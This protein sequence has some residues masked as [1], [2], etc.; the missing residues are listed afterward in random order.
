MSIKNIIYL[1]GS[2]QTQ[3]IAKQRQRDI[4]G[5]NVILISERNPI[6]A[7]EDPITASHYCHIDSLLQDDHGL[8]DGGRINDLY[9]VTIE[10]DGSASIK[11]LDIETLL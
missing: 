7:S 5:K 3:E 10:K 1:G 9:E 11:K 2:S 4:H 8:F 6:R